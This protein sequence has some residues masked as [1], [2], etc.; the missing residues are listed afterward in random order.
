[1]A[2]NLV[3]NHEEQYK[4]VIN[5]EE[6]YA[7]LPA[8]QRLPRGWSDAGKQGTLRQCT[9]FVEKLTRQSI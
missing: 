9:A 4:V 2:H 5:H 8:S 3:V 7:I 6:Q 1:M